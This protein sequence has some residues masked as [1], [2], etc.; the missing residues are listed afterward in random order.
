MTDQESPNDGQQHDSIIQPP[1]M[2]RPSQDSQVKKAQRTDTNGS[3]KAMAAPTEQT[4][5]TDPTQSYRAKVPF[6]RVRHAVKRTASTDVVDE[7]S[8]KK[9]ELLEH[10]RQSAV[11]KA[12]LKVLSP[13]SSD[14]LVDIVAIRDYY[15]DQS[16]AWTF[17]L[18][19][20]RKQLHNIPELLKQPSGEPRKAP[21]EPH[22]EKTSQQLEQDPAATTKS[23]S[24]A[25]DGIRAEPQS[26]PH[27][28]ILGYP[29]EISLFGPR[30]N[31][32]ANQPLSGPY[33]TQ[34]LHQETALEAVKKNTDRSRDHEDSN[35]LPLKPSLKS[36]PMPVFRRKSR[37]D[38]HVGQLQ[39]EITPSTDAAKERGLIISDHYV[40]LSINWLTHRQM[41]PQ[42]V[43]WAR[44]FSFDYL[45]QHKERSLSKA[46]RLQSLVSRLRS[47]LQQ[48]RQ[49]ERERPI[50]FI[51]HDFGFAIFLELLFSMKSPSPKTDQF[52]LRQAM[53]AAFIFLTPTDGVFGDVRISRYIRSQSMH[54]GVLQD[55]LPYAETR[56]QEY[57]DTHLQQV[58]R[59][60]RLVP[61]K[62]PR[63]YIQLML[64]DGKQFKDPFDKSFSHLVKNLTKATRARLLLQAAVDGRE[65]L[66][67]RYEERGWDLNLSDSSGRNALHF[68]II[69][70]RLEILLFL[71]NCKDIR[72]DAKDAAGQTALHYAVKTLS[73]PQGAIAMLVDNGADA[74]I[75]DNNGSTVLDIAR[76]K[77]IQ[78]SLKT[79]RAITGPSS[80]PGLILRLPDPNSLNELKQLAAEDCLMAVAEFFKVQE[81][82]VDVEKFIIQR[83]SV[84]QALYRMYPDEILDVARRKTDMKRE[85]RVCRW[86]HIPSN[87]TEWVDDLFARLGLAKE[88]VQVDQHSGKTYWSNYL[89]PH[90]RTFQAVHHPM[91]TTPDNPR[92]G[93]D[94]D[95]RRAPNE[96]Q[97]QG[98]LLYMPF[99]TFERHCDQRVIY[100]TIVGDKRSLVQDFY[101]V[102]GRQLLPPEPPEAS[103]ESD[104]EGHVRT[105]PTNSH[106]RGDGTDDTGNADQ[107]SRPASEKAESSDAES[108]AHSTAST[109]DNGRDNA[110]LRSER[111]LVYAFRDSITS[112]G[113]P[114]HVR[115][116]LDQSH[117]LMLEDTTKRDRDQVVLRRQQGRDGSK[118]SPASTSHDT[119]AEAETEADDLKDECPMVMV[120][121]MWLWVTGDTVISSFPRSW[122]QPEWEWECDVLDRLIEYINATQKR[123]PIRSSNDL[124]KLIVKHCVE[125][126]NH[127]QHDDHYHRLSL[128]DAFETSA[129]IVG[130]EEM[131]LFRQFEQQVFQLNEF[132]V[133]EEGT[134]ASDS[135]SETLSSSYYY[136]Y[137][138]TAN[139]RKTVSTKQSTKKKQKEVS[140]PSENKILDQLF[141]IKQEIEQLDE[142]KDVRDELRMILRILGEQKRVLGDWFDILA[143]PSKPEVK[144][145]MERIHDRHVSAGSVGV[146]AM[147]E[148]A[149][150][151]GHNQARNV[152]LK[153]A[154]DEAYVTI[155]S[156]FK[157]FSRMLDHVTATEK[158]INQLLNLKQKEA[159]SLEA[160]F[161][162]KSAEAATKQGNTVLFFTIVTIIFGSLSF[163]TTFFALNVTAFPLDPDSN[164]P[165]WGLKSV[166]GLI[167]GLSLGLSIPFILMALTINSTM[168]FGAK[169]VRKVTKVLSFIRFFPYLILVALFR[170]GR[171]KRRTKTSTFSSYYVSEAGYYGSRSRSSNGHSSTRS[172]SLHDGDRGEEMKIGWAA[173]AGQSLRQLRPRFKSKEKRPGVARSSGANGSSVISV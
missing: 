138:F 112:L 140:L 109:K 94:V 34:I 89:R 41:L 77:N 38:A 24:P 172:G 143:S 133:P 166:I 152:F 68:A 97:V 57:V 21:G 95:N 79:F 33:I 131:K 44:I 125:V 121:Q 47:Q 40:D 168:A 170:I 78:Q 36:T 88:S 73:R 65:D 171:L 66:L 28:P 22:E 163:I 103:D 111:E 142:A 26:Q 146:G 6:A 132:E 162:R 118:N 59:L 100:N 42:Q 155:Q 49:T 11:E 129:G 86:F 82:G 158:G 5:T 99:L 52:R 137:E 69:T 134:T 32:E 124:A 50:V 84:F 17:N 76:E 126:F 71:L 127:P 159:N 45:R 23:R 98:T 15:D 128:H 165:V 48:Y 119:D 39:D 92:R 173:K 93:V 85:T 12:T 136:E 149:A 31:Q 58:D 113:A 141:D 63:P 135:D 96:R 91:P 169:V 110:R 7:A 10:V 160:R 74:T 18:E 64:D 75:K 167:I 19:T 20:L 122:P 37:T 62:S 67:R 101:F 151:E 9:P 83:P 156:N 54:E 56:S 43:P 87:H 102:A 106:G 60:R 148:E 150:E 70:N 144:P 2:S 81:A 3:S 53:A 108:S 120:D 1:A 8:L 161:A 4:V 130:D 154:A 116:T 80:D 157:D 13:G 115:R 55:S 90:C 145:T 27:M 139:D 107:P 147:F 104:T 72:V 25:V 35:T 46:P 105:E 164:E 14:V 51:A 114:L 61:R 117:Y 16:T 153:D 30:N 29:S 123:G